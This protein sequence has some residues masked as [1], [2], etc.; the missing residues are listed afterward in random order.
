V[1]VLG[2]VKVPKYNELQ[3]ISI[4]KELLDNLDIKEVERAMA[5]LQV[6]EEQRFEQEFE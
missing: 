4:I 2:V 5:W 1:I 6:Y 3:T